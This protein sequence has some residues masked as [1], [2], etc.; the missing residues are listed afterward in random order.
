MNDSRRESINSSKEGTTE[1]SESDLNESINNQ[2]FSNNNE[3]IL[4][5]YY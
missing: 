3:E 1:N 4:D 5:D 2:R